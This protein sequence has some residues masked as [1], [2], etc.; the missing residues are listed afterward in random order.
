MNKMRMAVIIICAVVSILTLV[1]L[2]AVN[3]T[4]L[5]PACI[6]PNLSCP[7]CIVTC[8]AP[9][10]CPSCNPTLTCADSILK[11]E[12]LW[13]VTTNKRLCGEIVLGPSWVII[14]EE[15]LM[16]NKVKKMVKV[17]NCL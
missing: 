17:E 7:Q 10:A 12:G 13:E 14:N 2:V 9:P 15:T 4:E 11:V 3:A 8:E 5:T 16:L 6:P 1:M